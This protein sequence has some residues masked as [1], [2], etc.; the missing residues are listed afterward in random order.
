MSHFFTPYPL[1][2]Y[3]PTGQNAPSLAIDITRRFKLNEVT[4]NNSLIFYEYEIKDSDRPD[5]MAHKYY[6][7]SRLDWLF[8]IT[9]NL[10]DPYFQWPLNQKQFEDYIRQKYGSVSSA[11]AQNH[12][13]E[14]ILQLRQEYVPS[15][16]NEIIVIP[17]RSIQVDFA[18]Y[19]SLA[20][21]RRRSVDNFTFE[22]NENNR[23]R[24]IK[25]L[26]KVFI[27]NIMQDFRDIFDQ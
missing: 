18:T 12:H 10:F 24:N 4:K 1:V 16:D 22:E 15:Y 25:I 14:Q 6:E 20:P 19:T 13:Y 27:P 26:D 7:D 9:N 2:L 21:S 23:K 5:I 11:Q 17:E 3:D 8:F